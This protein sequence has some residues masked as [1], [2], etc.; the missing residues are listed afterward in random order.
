[1]SLHAQPDV[2][3]V[4]ILV[5]T[6]ELDVAVLPPLLPTV[7][8]LVAGADGVVLDLTSVTFFDSSGVR[9]VDALARACSQ[10]GAGFRV[11][12]PHRVVAR[13]VLELGGM[14]DALVDDDLEDAVAAVRR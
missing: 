12:A 8:T 2:D 6:G 1:M 11:V 10:A 13:R 5:G 7:P 9:L 3:G 14:A 4:R